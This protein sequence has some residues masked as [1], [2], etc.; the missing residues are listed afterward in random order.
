MIC[1]ACARF[2]I[3]IFE[4]LNLQ[5][6]KALWGRKVSDLGFAQFLSVLKWAVLKRG[7]Q[8]VSLDRFECTTGKCSGCSHEQS[9][10]LAERIFV[11]ENCGLSLDR[12]HNA[13]LDMLEAGRRLILSQSEAVPVT[14]A[15]SGAHVSFSHL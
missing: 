1:H 3:L 9:V 12:D 14:N 15:A 2:N 5:G 8:V 11:C 13:A 7:K 4:D 6:M 10:T